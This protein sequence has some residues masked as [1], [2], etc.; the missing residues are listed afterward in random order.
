MHSQKLAQ[1]RITKSVQKYIDIYEIKDDVV[2]L[3]DGSMR[4]VL[5]VSS[6]NFALKSE[7]E[8]SAIIQSYVQFLNSLN[9][10]LQIVIQSR[11]LNI[12]AYL[13]RLKNIEREQTNELLRI[14]TADYRKFV[15]ELVEIADIM[16]KH[17]YVAIPY[18]PYH[19]GEKKGFFSRF[20]EV[21]SPA[22]VITLQRQKFEKYKQELE[23]RVSLVSDGLASMGLTSVMLDTQSLIELY[24][25]TY[26]P[27]MYEHQRLTDLNAI[28]VVE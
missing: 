26:N 8:Q 24:Y 10:P 27:T 6:I 4:G 15:G 28:Q 17:F 19:K 14:Q 3:K 7:E 25:N 23:R 11:R 12:E 16:S 2:V 22:T 13:E 21:F 1:G 9:F 5:L 20:G 18:S